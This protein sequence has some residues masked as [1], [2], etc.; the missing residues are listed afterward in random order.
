MKPKVIIYLYNRLFDPVIQSNFWLFI[1]GELS[2][3]LSSIEFHLISYEDTNFPLTSEQQVLVTRW[4]SQGLHWHKLSWHSGLSIK[5]KVIDLWNGFKA[6]AG[7]RSKGMSKIISV[8]SISGGFVYLFSLVLPLK[9]FVYCYEPHSEYAAD[10]GIWN[11]DSIHYKLLNWLEKK[12]VKNAA[13]VSSGT[14]FME[15]RIKQEWKFDKPKF[16][17]IPTVVNDE[18]FTFNSSDRQSVRNEM[19]IEESMKVI[20]YPGKFGDLYYEHEIARMYRV[21]REGIDNLHFLIVSPNNKEY[22]VALFDKYAIPKTSYSITQSNYESI[23]RF[24]SAADFGII[25]VPPGQSK[26]FVSNIKV[27]EYL[28]AGLPYLITEGVSEDYLYATE[29]NVGVVVKGF[30]ESEIKLAIPEIETFL[31]QDSNRL[32]DHCRKIGQPYRGYSYLKNTF[33]R[34][35][36]ILNNE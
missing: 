4:K 16:L 11:R 33:S 9:R 28:C 36:N 15:K 34:A 18:K 21:L 30:S 23:H 6:I 22:I 25:A 29:K 19:G 35:L 13:I 1:D 20:F 7:L 10:N 2:S 24:F 12:C 32:R 26:K 14:K 8:A 17:K 27:G 3:H 5:A 31:N